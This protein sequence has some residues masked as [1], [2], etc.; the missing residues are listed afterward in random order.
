MYSK[1]FFDGLN[2]SQG[3]S[4]SSPAGEARTVASLATHSKLICL[5]RENGQPFQIV[6]EAQY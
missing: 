1:P 3:E 4:V 6:A 2:Y 5:R